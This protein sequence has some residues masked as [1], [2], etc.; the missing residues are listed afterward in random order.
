MASKI[1]LLLISDQQ[2]PY[3]AFLQF[4]WLSQP[5]LGIPDI[6]RQSCLCEN[7][8]NHFPHIKIHALSDV[9]SAEKMFG[10][11]HTKF[12]IFFFFNSYYAVIQFQ[13]RSLLQVCVMIVDG[14]TV[15]NMKCKIRIVSDLL[16]H[17]HRITDTHRQKL[18]KKVKYNRRNLLVDASKEVNYWVN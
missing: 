12:I 17:R 7:S 5:H 16:V 3:R 14:T 4:F 8:V 11:D 15:A 13:W 6:L 18:K 2:T 9:S 1:S 10:N